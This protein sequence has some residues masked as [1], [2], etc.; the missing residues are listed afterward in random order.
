MHELFLIAHLSDD[1]FQRAL[2]IF[3]GYCGMSPVTLLR[4]RMIFEGPRLKHFKGID[5]TLILS[6]RRENQ[7]LWKTLHEQIIRQSY[8]ITL[9]FDINKDDFGQP[10]VPESQGLVNEP[11]KEQP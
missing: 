4:R 10:S 9:I 7:Q 5:P 8:F 3:Q 1:D 6:Q 2:R 11:G